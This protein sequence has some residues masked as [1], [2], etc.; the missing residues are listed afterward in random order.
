MSVIGGWIMIPH[1]L[2][3]GAWFEEFLEPS[4]AVAKELAPIHGSHSLPFEYSIMG[5]SVLMIKLSFF[6][7]THQMWRL[8]FT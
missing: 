8:G 1:A 3:G 2:G 7:N 6:G 5:I 4:F